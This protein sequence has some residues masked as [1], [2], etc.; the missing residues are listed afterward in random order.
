MAKE[1]PQNR[2]ERMVEATER[3]E[4]KILRKPQEVSVDFYE[5]FYMQYHQ[6]VIRYL[7]GKCASYQDAEDLAN[8]CFLYCFQHWSD[9]DSRKASRKNWLFMIVRS[10]WIN[11]LRDRRQMES[12]DELENIIPGEDE[13]EQAIRLQAIRD[14]LAQLLESLPDRQ[15]E[16]IVLRAFQ[17]WTDEEIADWMGVSKGNV[18]VMIHRGI[19]KMNRKFSDY[20]RTVLAE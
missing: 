7:A 10:R 12:L 18:R 13:L 20:L 9:Y 19:Q 1:N 17:Q 4:A 5:C 16:A 3:K 6:K 11:Y 14:E 15:R 2:G 8:E